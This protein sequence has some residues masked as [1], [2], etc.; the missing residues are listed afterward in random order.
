MR[1]MAIDYGTKRVGISLSDERG[2]F[3]FAH[4]VAKADKHLVPTLAALCKEKAVGAIVVGE[5]RNFK[6]EE[7]PIMKQVHA[8]VK[9]LQEAA[10]IP[11]ILEPEFMTS[12]EA[13]HIQGAGD[14]LDASAAALILKS[15]LDK[16]ANNAL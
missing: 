1:Y 14:M 8:F 11:V 12:A 4:A 15:Y 7:N 10:G 2:E 16:K 9:N 5:S 6:G 3:A 13:S